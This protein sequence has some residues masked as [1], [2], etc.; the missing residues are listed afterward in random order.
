MPDGLDVGIIQ[1]VIRLIE[2]DP[3]PHAFSHL[4]PVGDIRHDRLT[5]E[6]REFSDTNSR[7]DLCF[8]VALDLALLFQEFFDF[9]FHRKAVRIPAGFSRYVIALHRLVARENIFKTARQNVVNSRLAIRCRRPFIKAELR[10]TFC[11]IQCFLKNVVLTPKLQDLRF[12][13]RPVIA[14]LNFFK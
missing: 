7:F 10:S 8:V 3:E 4:L 13:I 2:I 12:E 11:L 14:S 1:R 6:S 9:M 5:A